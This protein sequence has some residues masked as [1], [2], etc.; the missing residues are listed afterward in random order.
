M[1]LHD[2]TTAVK[3]VIQTNEK[4]KNLYQ[5]LVCLHSTGWQKAQKKSPKKKKEVGEKSDKSITNMN[6]TLAKCMSESL[7]VEILSE[8]NLDLVRPSF[9]L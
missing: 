7:E 5:F 3:I 1:H 8:N 2:I 4:I 6:L 9:H